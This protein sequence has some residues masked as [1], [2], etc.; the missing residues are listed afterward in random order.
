MGLA[1]RSIMRSI[2][3]LGRLVS[4]TKLPAISE[5]RQSSSRTYRL[6]RMPG[7]I[8]SMK[9]NM[10]WFAQVFGQL[11]SEDSSVSPRESSVRLWICTVRCAPV[12]SSSSISR[13]GRAVR[14]W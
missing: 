11:I 10:Q 7:G 12:S 1:L 2:S 13:E 14:N 9:Q 5:S 3:A 4:V 8:C 6:G